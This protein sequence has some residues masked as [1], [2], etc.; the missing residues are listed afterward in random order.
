MPSNLWKVIIKKWC[1]PTLYVENRRRR[2]RCKNC[3][4]VSALRYWAWLTR[5]VRECLVMVLRQADCPSTKHLCGGL[6]LKL[7]GYWNDFLHF[8]AETHSRNLAGN[9]SSRLQFALGSCGPIIG[10]RR[11]QLGLLLVFLQPPSPKST[12]R[13]TSSVCSGLVL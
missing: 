10:A 2:C 4:V 6:R 7:R 11:Y 5:E 9:I 13:C 3:S 1:W 8:W 12:W